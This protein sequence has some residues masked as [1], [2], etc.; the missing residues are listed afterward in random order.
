MDKKRPPYPQGNSPLREAKQ[1]KYTPT[2]EEDEY[3][4]RR[5]EELR[6]QLR[7]K[8]DSLPKSTDALRDPSTYDRSTTHFSFGGRMAAEREKSPF[9]LAPS[10]FPA[11]SMTY[12]SLDPPHHIKEH[13]A[14]LQ[15]DNTSL[16]RRLNLVLAELERV[17]REKEDLGLRSSQTSKSVNDLQK[18]ISGEDSMDKVNRYM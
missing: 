7:Q 6:R 4:R 5:E 10:T 13:M 8:E 2:I 16:M 18:V 1:P 14:N 17:Q 3:N 9:S 12:P 15:S 11:E